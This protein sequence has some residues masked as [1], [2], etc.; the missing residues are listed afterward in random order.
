MHYKDKKWKHGTV[1]Y[2]ENIK[3]IIIRGFL[4]FQLKILKLHLLWIPTSLRSLKYSENLHTVL[5]DWKSK[6]ASVWSEKG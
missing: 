3:D 5:N 1:S 4:S 6:R 2:L